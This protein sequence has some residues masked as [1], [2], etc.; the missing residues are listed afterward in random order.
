M[1]WNEIEECFMSENVKVPFGFH[2]C[3]LVLDG[4]VLPTKSFMINNNTP[5]TVEI[6]F[7]GGMLTFMHCLYLSTSILPQLLTLFHCVSVYKNP[8]SK[9]Q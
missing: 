3:Q 1:K 8:I 4:D 6:F 2:E 5:K 7:A 9:D